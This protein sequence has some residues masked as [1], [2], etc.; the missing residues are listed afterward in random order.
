M[1]ER[2]VLLSCLPKFEILTLY[3]KEVGVLMK[4]KGKEVEEKNAVPKRM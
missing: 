4:K 1:K 2:L 3:S